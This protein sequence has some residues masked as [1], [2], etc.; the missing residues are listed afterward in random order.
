MHEC[1]ES[2]VAAAVAIAAAAGF[3]AAPTIT[4]VPITTFL[5]AAVADAANAQQPEL[6]RALANLGVSSCE[7]CALEGGSS[8]TI[9]WLLTTVPEPPW[10]LV[11]R[12]SEAPKIKL[13]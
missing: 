7:Q 10:S 1:T 3:T 12:P 9:P 8:W 13:L 6:A 2:S 11:Q 5:L 4:V